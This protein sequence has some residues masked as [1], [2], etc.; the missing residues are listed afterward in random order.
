[1]G[2]TTAIIMGIIT[3]MPM[4]DMAATPICARPISISLPMR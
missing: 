4:T 1:M 3:T 2:M